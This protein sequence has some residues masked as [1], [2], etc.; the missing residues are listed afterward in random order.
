MYICMY[1][2]CRCF[3]LRRRMTSAAWLGCIVRA[4]LWRW[5]PRRMP[6][7]I[8][9]EAVHTLLPIHFNAFLS[10]LYVCIY[11][12]L[13]YYLPS[14]LHTYIYTYLDTYIHTFKVL[15]A[16]RSSYINTYIQI[17]RSSAPCS[18][19]VPSESMGS[20]RPW[21]HCQGMYV[22]CSGP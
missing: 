4:A 3:C 21:E 18:S 15:N 7:Y 19:A 22:W 17:D 5:A 10:V 2:R 20:G 16:E 12:S 6:P 13:S 9:K 11:V 14:Y 8:E 1:G